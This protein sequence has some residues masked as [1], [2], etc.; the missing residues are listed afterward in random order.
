[1]E[2]SPCKDCKE[3]QVGCH[4]TCEK[5]LEWNKKWVDNK[6]KISEKKYLMKQIDSHEISTNGFSNSYIQMAAKP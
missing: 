4:S 2:T 6:I 3:R 5:Y 1:M